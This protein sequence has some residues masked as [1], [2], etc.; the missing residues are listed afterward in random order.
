MCNC[1]CSCIKHKR[2]ADYRQRA[3]LSKEKMPN[4]FVNCIR[5]DEC[6]AP[7]PGSFGK[8]KPKCDEQIANPIAGNLLLWLV[9]DSLSSGKRKEMGETS[10]GFS[11]LLGPGIWYICVFMSC[12][13]YLSPLSQ[14]QWLPLQT[15]RA[16][17]CFKQSGN[18]AREPGQN[19]VP[20]LW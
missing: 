14:L 15:K 17:W 12:V 7:P 3:E 9:L 4:Y 13:S 6:C 1:S 2:S 5:D 19:F 10:S 11:P 8:G 18:R 20:I 16:K